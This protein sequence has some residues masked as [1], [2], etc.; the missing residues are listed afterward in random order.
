MYTVCF[1]FVKENYS[2]IAYFLMVINLN[3][4]I[5][6]TPG[7]KKEKKSISLSSRLAW[8]TWQ[9]SRIVNGIEKIVFVCLFVGSMCTVKLRDRPTPCSVCNTVLR[10]VHQAMVGGP[11]TMSHRRA[12]VLFLRKTKIKA[13]KDNLTVSQFQS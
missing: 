6:Y 7:K 3:N 10:T 12:V 11:I 1:L 5:S 13:Q 8:A 4:Q 9:Y 2:I